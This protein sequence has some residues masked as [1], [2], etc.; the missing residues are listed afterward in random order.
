MESI[1]RKIAVLGVVFLVSVGLGCRSQPVA[2]IA[3]TKEVIKT[4]PYGEPDPVPIMTRSS[5]WGRGSRLYPYS[6]ID[7]F[8]QEADDREWT[9][10]T[11]EN[12]Y[13]KV[14]VLPEVGGKIWGALEKSTKQEFIY[15]NHVLKFREVALRGP[16]TSGG[17]EF[18]FGIVG[19]TPAGAHPVDYFLRQNPDGSATCFVGTRD[20]PSRS[21]W[22]VAVTVPR[23][24]AYFETKALWT[25]PSPFHQAYYCW[26]NGAIRIGD[27]LQYIFPGRFHIA[28][29]FSVPLRPWSIDADGRNLAW[30][31]NNDFGSYK[32]YFT[33][34]EYEDFFGGYWHDSKFGFG[35]WARYD[36]MPGQKIWIWGLSRQ[37]MIW[38]DLLT[39]ADG[40]YSEPQAGRYFNQNDHALFPPFATDIWREIWFPYKEIGPMVKASP[41]G[42][43]H[44]Q[45]HQQEN[46]LIIGIC[47][48][49]KL[50]EALVVIADGQE[51][52]REL[53]NLNPMETLVKNLNLDANFTS[54]EVQAGRHL[55]FRT[56]P[57]ANDLQRP[58]NFHAYAEDS[59]EGLFLAAERLE[60]ERSY[61]QALD[62]YQSILEQDPLHTRALCRTAELLCR[63]GDYAQ[64]SILTTR[65]LQN[66]MYDPETN[67]IYGVI[68]R[69]QGNLIDAK[70]AWGWAS[71]SLRFRS[72][73]Y[74]QMAEI[75][76]LE[77]KLE[78]ARE[79]AQRALDYD[80][81]NLNALQ[82]KAIAYRK[83]EAVL[84]AS[85]VIER[86]LAFDPLNHL[87]RFEKYLLQPSQNN[88]LAFQTMIRNELPHEDY[89]EM[90]LYYLSLGLREEAVQML[91]LS[92]QYPTVNYWLAYLLK[93]IHPQ[94]S[95]EN[96][97]LANNSSPHLVFPFREESIPVFL[98]AQAKSPQEWQ[99]KYYLGLIY[100]NQGQIAKTKELFQQCGEPDF[101]PFYIAR[102]YFYRDSDPGRA[103][104]DYVSALRLEDSNWRYWLHLI[105]FY[106]EKKMPQPALK[107]AEQALAQLPDEVPL[108]IEMIRAL[109]GNRFYKRAA[110][111]LD[112]LQALPSEGATALHDLFEHCHNHLGWELM[113]VGD[114][115][116][117]I[118]HFEKAKTYPERLGSGK[119]Y[120]PDN[121]LQDFFLALCFEQTGEKQK[122]QE[123]RQNVQSYTLRFWPEPKKYPYYGGLVLGLLGEQDKAVKLMALGKPEPAARNI[124]RKMMKK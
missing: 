59:I 121:R 113:Q 116:A 70:E 60:S 25:N 102:A 119:P 35:H 80:V 17:I 110:E 124:I 12:P 111:M 94:Q 29:N 85:Q 2:R 22:T 67:Y 26:M 98:W 69:K 99:V 107:A 78:D 104:T 49:Q 36:D 79:Y 91:K 5:L 122:A 7:R 21:R 114:F 16:W 11:L 6:F 1:I 56:D 33:V 62:K 71:R 30:Y 117:A 18:N 47:P 72:A 28:H 55:S 97:K 74:S 13:I 45:H 31:K 52:Y 81:H 84:E 37:G 32:S 95:Q 8:S 34:G 101:A 123:I 96:F 43:L 75:Y 27:D 42:V 105:N 44:V 54:F 109:L 89:L 82:V 64:A 73:A 19:H 76:L 63:R 46:V 23:D 41:Q 48:L 68:S 77:N 92:P 115:K 20:W 58:I 61:F 39:D 86:I 15:T 106:N 93:D 90:A 103:L 112:M 24:K 51:I 38:E 100:W 83:S 118:T 10:I 40:Q 53:L 4:Y 14:Q 57:Q 66:V 65:A 88:L 9:I 87:A 3:E 120:D 108:Q 50:E